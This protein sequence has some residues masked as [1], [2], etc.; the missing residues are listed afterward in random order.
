PSLRKEVSN[1][2][3]WIL[4]SCIGSLLAAIGIIVAFAAYQASWFQ[5]SLNENRE[6]AREASKTAQQSLEKVQ[7]TMDEIV[8]LRISSDRANAER[9]AEEK[10]V[11]RR[12]DRLE[13]AKNK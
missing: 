5:H 11:E 2:K 4:G 10:Q 12:L 9:L 6:Q 7:Q 13:E 8:R 1:V 3:Y